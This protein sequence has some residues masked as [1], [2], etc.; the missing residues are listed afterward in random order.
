MCWI[1]PFWK[2]HLQIQLRRTNEF[3][4]RDERNSK[5]SI[6]I[7]HNL[8]IR[9]E[10]HINRRWILLSLSSKRCTEQLNRRLSHS[11]KSKNSSVFEILSRISISPNMIALG[12]L[13]SEYEVLPRSGSYEQIAIER[14][15][16]VTYII[17]LINIH[18]WSM[19]DS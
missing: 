9:I 19:S 12:F 6:N 17:D 4:K 3:R 18:F 11:R 5:S 16:W 13:V 8:V 10:V 15:D 7:S 14:D 2:N 1:L